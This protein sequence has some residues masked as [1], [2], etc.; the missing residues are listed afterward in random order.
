MTRSP[1]LARLATWVAVGVVLALTVAPFVAGLHARE[2]FPP[3]GADAAAPVAADAWHEV[4]DAFLRLPLAAVLGM[5]LALRPRHKGQARRNALVIQTQIVLAVVGAVVML[6]VNQS[7]ARAF[8]IAGA[9]NLVRYRST[10]DDPKEAVVMLCALSAGLAAGVGL[11][12]LAPLA[13]VF[14]GL[15]LL[16]SRRLAVTQVV[17]YLM[18]ENGIFVF[19]LVLATELPTI[20]EMGVLLDIFVG[21]FIMGIT[22]FQINREF[23]HMDASRLQELQDTEGER[24]WLRLGPRDHASD[25]EGR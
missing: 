14:M 9:S 10:I 12:A 8:A 18:L 3:P 5:I 17:G 19:S 21:V 11:Y 6:V 24:R 22:I 20:V 16:V 2:Q 4:H 25:P 15:L 13:T 7:L 1:Y 23:D